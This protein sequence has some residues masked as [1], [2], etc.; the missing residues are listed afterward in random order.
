MGTVHNLNDFIAKNGGSILDMDEELE[1]QFEDK[2]ERIAWG[3]VYNCGFKKMPDSA[4]THEAEYRKWCWKSAGMMPKKRARGYEFDDYIRERM[5]RAT[6]RETL[7]GLE[8]GAIV[9]N[10]VLMHIRTQLGWSGEIRGLDWQDDKSAEQKYKVRTKAVRDLDNLGPGE[11]KD[12]GYREDMFVETREDTGFGGKAVFVRIEPLMWWI[13]EVARHGLTETKITREE[14]CRWLEKHGKH[15]DK[16]ATP[17]RV[18]STY[19][20]ALPFVWED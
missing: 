2:E 1:I 14:V 3:R 16:S 4:L 20:L 15:Y 10:I 17:S 11:K 8:D 13:T 18:Q 19:A 12:L 5:A 7:P 9:K 6:I